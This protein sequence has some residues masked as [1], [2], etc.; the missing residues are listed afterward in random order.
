MNTIRTLL[1]ALLVA[2][3]AGAAQAQE[4]FQVTGNGENFAVEYAPGYTGNIV[5]GGVLRD[6]TTG[7]DP[8]AIYTAPNVSQTAGIP[9]FTGGSQGDVVYTPVGVAPA[10]MAG[11]SNQG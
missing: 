1:A 3:A 6:T 7:K 4:P 8:R 9:S 11:G 5:G 10:L 2:G